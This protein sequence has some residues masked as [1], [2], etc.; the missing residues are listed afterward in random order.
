MRQNK[1]DLIILTK[2]EYEVLKKELAKAHFI[3]LKYQAN[4]TCN[5]AK[6]FILHGELK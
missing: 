3:N 6:D 5:C 4:C 1:E 2:V